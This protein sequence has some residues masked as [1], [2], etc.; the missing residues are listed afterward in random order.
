MTTREITPEL[1]RAKRYVLQGYRGDRLAKALGVGKTKAH[2]LV[3]QL[4]FM[5]Q[6]VDITGDPT[7]TPRIYDDPENPT[8]I[9][10]EKPAPQ[11]P[12]RADAEVPSS[13]ACGPSPRPNKLVR[14]HCTGAYE[15][16][17]LILGN[18]D[19]PI[20]D[21]RGVEVGGWSELKDCKG[22]IR[23][24]GHA[25]LTPN[26]SLHFTLYHA[27]AGP[28]LTITPNPR[29][30]YYLTADTEGPA[31]LM[32]QVNDLW[33]LL[34]YTQGWRLESPI[35]KG[36]YHY[37]TVGDS[38]APLLKYIDRQT[39]ID[40]AAVHVDTSNGYPE[41]EIYGDHPGA[42]EDV[43]IL[44]ELPQ[45]IRGITASLSQMTA[46]LTQISA[47]LEQL[48]NITAQ[49]SNVQASL[50]DVI[51]RQPYYMTPASDNRGYY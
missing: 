11:I 45:R 9:S 1:K 4:V 40:N 38:F 6:L 28:K 51:T 12:E 13:K 27:R 16:A 19:G 7:S 33:N 18:H 15:V 32:E 48:T 21:A 44:Y 22:S 42:G 17:V 43:R 31:Q 23:Q 47:N 37:A 8:L 25:E 10:I 3:K 2:N 5:G 24:Y 30:V 34:T 14:F 36:T 35:F 46:S 50:T 26:E 20:I 29:N 49:L 41:I 39:D